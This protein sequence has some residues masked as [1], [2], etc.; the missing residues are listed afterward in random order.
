MPL[1]TEELQNKA[2]AV[3]IKYLAY[4]DEFVRINNQLADVIRELPSLQNMVCSECGGSLEGFCGPIF[5]V[6]PVVRDY[7]GD[8]VIPDEET[9]F[10]MIDGMKHI[11]FIQ[12]TECYAIYKFD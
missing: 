10:K 9:G 4:R 3:E 1:P 5:E 2:T 12:C 8:I 6:G 11:E 7:R